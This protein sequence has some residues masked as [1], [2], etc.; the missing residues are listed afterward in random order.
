MPHGNEPFMAA[1]NAKRHAAR[2]AGS[3]F[4]H[5]DIIPESSTPPLS[6]GDRCPSATPFRKIFPQPLSTFARNGEPWNPIHA[7]R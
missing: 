3:I 4:E 5:S 2:Q 6:K 1:E 7:P